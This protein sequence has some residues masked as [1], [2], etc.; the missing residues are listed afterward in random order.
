MHLIDARTFETHD[1]IR[2]P[3]LQRPKPK[4]R[5]PSV[6]TSTATSN[7][8]STSSRRVIPS[9]STAAGSSAGEGANL[10][11]HRTIRRGVP[12]TSHARLT[13]TG[14]TSNVRQEPPGWGTS[15]P[16]SPD[17]S[18]LLRPMPSSLSMPPSPPSPPLASNHLPPSMT[19]PSPPRAHG[20]LGP[21]HHFATRFATRGG[22]PRRNEAAATFV[23]GINTLAEPRA[24]TM[25]R[26]RSE[27]PAQQTHTPGIVQALGDTFRIPGMGVSPSSPPRPASSGSGTYSPPA[28]IGDST[29]R[30]LGGGVGPSSTTTVARPSTPPWARLVDLASEHGEDNHEDED[31]DEMT[32]DEYDARTHTAN[33]PGHEWGPLGPLGSTVRH[34]LNR[35]EGGIF[36]TD[37][38]DIV[39]VPDLGD[40]DVES[41]VHALLAVHGI[42]TRSPEGSAGG[43]N[44]S[45]GDEVDEVYRGYA[46]MDRFMYDYFEREPEHAVSRSTVGAE[47]G[48]SHHQEELHEESDGMD[49]DGD[50]RRNEDEGEEEGEEDEDTECFSDVDED[51]SRIGS[52]FSASRR[53]RSSSSPSWQ[54]ASPTSRGHT[55]TSSDYKSSH[56]SLTSSRGNTSTRKYGY[57]DGLDIAG[58]CFDPWG[59]RMYVAGVG[60]G[61]GNPGR[62]V[63]MR[64]SLVSG[65]GVGMGAVV[66][67]GVRGAEKRWFV[68]D[69][70]R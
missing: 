21:R 60:I 51:S 65:E 31:D 2:V 61:I 67:W 22:R 14:S 53:I 59:E 18:G 58:M 45:G 62:L 52:S 41:D 49:V 28:S 29:W 24:S 35:A 8:R 1:I 68:D 6:A 42:P 12:P 3:T 36:D 5:A 48:S 70:W 26:A 16:Y 23:A 66:E 10:Q 57:Y 34:R 15:D 9:S 69:G 39:V 33:P 11:R 47:Y 38:D 7:T 17:W 44:G 56:S 13:R 30:T 46:D 20:G 55:P 27:S 54:L 32:V 25:P 40:R 64:G 37:D 19:P 43:S 50:E 4:L 63:G